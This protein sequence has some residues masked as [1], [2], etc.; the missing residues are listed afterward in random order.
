MPET[1][2]KLAWFRIFHAALVAHDLGGV[3]RLVIDDGRRV[4][5]GRVPAPDRPL[6]A[7]RYDGAKPHRHDRVGTRLRVC[8]RLR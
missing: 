3:W 1:E 8:A 5:P 7:P 2:R 6:V 4:L